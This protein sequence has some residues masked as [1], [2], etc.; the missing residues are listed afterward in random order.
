MLCACQFEN[1]D[2]FVETFG[3]IATDAYKT[4]KQIKKQITPRKR[5]NEQ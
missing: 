4:N 3:K 1:P 2:G 5:K